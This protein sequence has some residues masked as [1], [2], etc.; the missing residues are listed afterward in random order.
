MKV[1]RSKVYRSLAVLILLVL[2]AYGLRR[3]PMLSNDFAGTYISSSGSQQLIFSVFP[4]KQSV[5]Y[6][7]QA[8]NIYI[9]GSF[10]PKGNDSYLIVF[11]DAP[12]IP[13]QILVCEDLTFQL[14][15]GDEKMLF[16]KISKAATVFS[17]RGED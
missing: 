7:D 2:V 13:E 11:E 10:A 15:V 3:I 12:V 14:C 16:R 1:F 4:L 6:A 9:W 8:Q 17:G 5:Y